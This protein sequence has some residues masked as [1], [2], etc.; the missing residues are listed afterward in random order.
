VPLKNPG[1]L[2]APLFVAHG[3]ADSVVPCSQ[4][5]ALEGFLARSLGPG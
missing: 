5:A 3:Q 2:Q 4:G 1:A